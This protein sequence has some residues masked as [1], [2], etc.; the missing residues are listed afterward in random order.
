MKTLKV[1]NNDEKIFIGETYEN[2][3][4]YLPTGQTVLLTD[5]NVYRYYKSFIAKYNHIVISAGESS[6]SWQTIE[7][8]IKEL[9]KLNADRHTFIVG[10]GGGVVTDITGFVASIFMRGISFGFVSSSL[11]S[12]VDAS[13]GGKNG[14]NLAG[15]K[16]IIGSF[17]LPKFVICDSTLLKTL[18]DQQLRNG[19]G[20]LLKHAIIKDKELFKNLY[21]NATKLLQR[22]DFDLIDESIYRSLQIKASVVNNDF[23]EKGERKILNFGHTFAHAVENNSNLLHGEAVAVGMVF[24]TKFSN[25]KEWLSDNDSCRIEELI[26]RFELPTSIA[27]NPRI[28]YSFIE[29]DKKK[30][31]ETIDFVFLEKIGKAK[32]KEISLK[33]LFEFIEKREFNE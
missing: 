18:D 1:G 17:D 4:K 20:E 2:I 19:F 26:K 24:A 28:L 22:K 33:E 25:K 21:A 7:Y 27:I 12:Q 8:I 29:K 6:K 23:L 14:I 32:I 5:S 10:F 9:L 3:N 31:G 11:L 13:V 15:Y 16:N 30:K